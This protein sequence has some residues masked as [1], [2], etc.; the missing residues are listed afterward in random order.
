MYRSHI[1]INCA[2]ILLAITLSACGGGGGGDNGNGGGPVIPDI[3]NVNFSEDT[4]LNGD[5]GG[6]WI[7]T[8]HMERP[9]SMSTTSN[10]ETDIHEAFLIIDDPTNGLSVLSCGTEVENLA[11]GSNSLAFRLYQN[12]YELS[13]DSNTHL[14]G[15][16]ASA[17]G[18]AGNITM[19]KVMAAPDDL[20]NL[21]LGTLRYSYNGGSE[22]TANIQCY[23]EEH[24]FSRYQSST[25]SYSHFESIYTLGDFF[26]NYVSFRTSYYDDEDEEFLLITLNKNGMLDQFTNDSSD[27]NVEFLI[28]GTDEINASFQATDSNHFVNGATSS[29]TLTGSARLNF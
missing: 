18:D 17:Y 16:I 5:L 2:A 22:V 1:I 24:Y 15:S 19:I 20:I 3:E 26:Q 21:S 6:V 29:V 13:I 11:T 14:S 8:I 27:E 28:R 25:E 9:S 7:A 4:T 12:N 10:S 23:R